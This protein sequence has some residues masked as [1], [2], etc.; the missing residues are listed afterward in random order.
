MTATDTA[1]L[2]LTAGLLLYAGGL[3]APR[4]DRGRN[5]GPTSITTAR[6]GCAWRSAGCWGRRSA[7]STATPATTAAAR[8][9]WNGQREGNQLPGR[10]SSDSHHDELPVL[11]HV[12]HR[13]TRLI[14]RH[15]QLGDVL[16]C[17]LVVRMQ[18]RT[19]APALTAE[20]KRLGHQ[21]SSLRQESRWV[22]H[23][24]DRAWRTL[25]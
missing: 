5:N 1:T 16:A 12:G 14:T 20:E 23:S 10:L 24:S 19:S 11:V 15:R 4:G 25:P 2:A 17:L 18:Q 7:T 3:F 22:E 13:H 6:G 8:S 9:A 21:E